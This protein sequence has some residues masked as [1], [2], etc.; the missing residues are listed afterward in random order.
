MKDYTRDRILC[1]CRSGINRSRKA[2]DIL[3]S[4]GYISDYIGISAQKETINLKLKWACLLII[5]ELD[6]LNWLKSHYERLITDREIIVLEIKDLYDYTDI[7]LETIIIN[8]LKNKGL[9]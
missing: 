1:I 2:Y 8:K 5:M 4:N 3:E 9:L 7:A 6:Q